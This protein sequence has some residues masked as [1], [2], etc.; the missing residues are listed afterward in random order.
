MSTY[1]QV[2]DVV[3]R[4]GARKVDASTRP[5]TGDVQSWLDEGEALLNGALQSAG[6][7]A[8]Y[9]DPDAVLRLRAW[10]CEY[11]LG[12][13]ERS[14]ALGRGDAPASDLVTK[15]YGRLDDITANP[16]RYGAMLGAGAPPANTSRLRASNL[17]GAI[18]PEFR[19][20]KVWY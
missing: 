7:P 18:A 13:L 5:S 20:G 3:A 11:G 15:F 8:P 1:A 16:G 14:Q 2:A 9:T 10:L 19:R 4:A 12:M 6:L 17:D